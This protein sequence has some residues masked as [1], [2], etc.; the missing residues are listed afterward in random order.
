MINSHTSGQSAAHGRE[1]MGYTLNTDTEYGTK[2]YIKED[3]VVT[4]IQN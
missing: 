1:M 2:S 3:L 4:F